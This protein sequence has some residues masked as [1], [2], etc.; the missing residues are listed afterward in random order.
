MVWH[1]I[2]GVEMSVNNTCRI[3]NQSESPNHSVFSSVS[4]ISRS[5]STSNALLTRSFGYLPKTNVLPRY[6]A[7][8]K[9]EAFKPDRS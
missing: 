4:F 6:A 7:E 3:E 2:T 8:A 1:W 5:G 9:E